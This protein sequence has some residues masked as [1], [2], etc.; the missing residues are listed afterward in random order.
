MTSLTGLSEESVGEEEPAK[1]LL[2]VASWSI[3]G[4]VAGAIA[5]TI[6]NGKLPEVQAIGPL[7]VNQAVK[8]VIIARSYLAEEGVEV[9]CIPELIEITGIDGQELPAIK[10]VVKPR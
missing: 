10:L 7:A 6:R 8:A 5:G 2:K 1:R 3:P 9:I 4:K